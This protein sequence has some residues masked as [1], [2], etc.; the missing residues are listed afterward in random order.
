MYYNW[1]KETNTEELKIVC[2]L[3][4]NGEVVVF[5]TETVYGIGAN[6]LD[7]DAVGKVFRKEDRESYYRLFLLVRLIRDINDIS[8]D[9]LIKKE[10]YFLKQSKKKAKK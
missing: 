10:K 2:N 9:D 4:K 6:A 8:R 1:S 7:K 5:P 3:I